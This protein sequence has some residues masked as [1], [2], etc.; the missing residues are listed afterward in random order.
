MM[1]AE[2]DH[3]DPRG[4][5]SDAR[6]S[7]SCPAQQ[8]LNGIGA[9]PGIAIGR[10][11]IFARDDFDVARRELDEDLLD[12]EVR[13]FERAVERS[14]R[15]LRKIASVAKEKLG[16]AS[17]D[18][19]EAQ[20]L[21]LR[22]EALYH[23]VLDEIQER[24]HNA[25]F[26]VKT[27]MSS[28]QRRML[29]SS[30]EYLRE[31]SNDLLDVQERLIRHLQRGKLLSAI[32]KDRIVVAEN[33]TAADVL[34]FSRRGVLGC[35]TDF[36]GPT[37]HVSIMA[38]SL[39]VPA[40]VSLRGLA[41]Q[42]RDG[43]LIILDGLTGRVVLNP[44]AGTL[45]RYQTQL[46]RYRRLLQEQKQIV[47][48]PADTVDGHH[49]SLMAN[50]EFREELGL[51]DEYGAE[52]V[53]LF[54]TEILFLMKGRLSYSEDDQFN[55]YRDIV[56]AVRPRPTTFRLL[57]LGGD[58]MLPMAHR[59]QN[60]FLGWRGVRILLDKPEL[61]VP[62]VRAL[63]RASAHGPI[64]VLLPMV[65]GLD[66]VRRI[67]QVIDDARRD[68]HA[69]GVPVADDVPLGIMVEV[70]A[71]ALMAGQYAAEVDFLS[72]GTN[73]LTQYTLAVDRGNDLVSPMYNELHPAVLTLIKQTVDAARLH[74]IRVSLCGE[75]A[76]RPR[77]I[78]LLVGL[79]VHELSASPSYLAEIKRVIRVVELR[80]AQ[81]LAAEA[82]GVRSA[83]EVE[84][85]MDR[86]LDEHPCGLM[87]QFLDADTIESGG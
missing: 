30:N 18:I 56:E 51:L 87:M 65:T 85:I 74:G 17:S 41:S 12:D 44:D 6:P 20:L 32:D 58:K 77:A 42:V 81:Q 68:L 61:L 10:V 27:V 25:D 43:D 8:V 73:D 38:R 64:R 16:E 9:A 72:L 62:Q 21:M 13:R 22:D 79:G 7:A 80:E 84:E 1:T 78:P 4:D 39:G 34:L 53:G 67:R 45:E 35:A 57:D 82:L 66:E 49:V 52:G 24:R 11:T 75:L 59:E 14:E 26:A 76:G 33:L 86:W 60:P 70:P 37:S 47:P 28:H 54:R 3:R 46:K 48:L 63:L 2:P 31:R 71:V 36:G 40:V 19:F 69:E 83:D 29:A 23:A 5:G 15:D 50:L 55:V